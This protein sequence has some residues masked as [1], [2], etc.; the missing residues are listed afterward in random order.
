[1]NRI[2]TLLMIIG[3]LPLFL[4]IAAMVKLDSSGPVIFSQKRV[5]QQGRLF[6]MHKFRTMVVGMPDLPSDQ[7]NE[8]DSRITKVGRIL[9]RL[10]LDELPQLWN[11]MR[12][13]MNF[14]GPR[15]AL[16][17]QYE[18]IAMRM[19]QGIDSL[20]PGITG[21]AQVNGRDSISLERKVELDHY[22]LQHRSWNLDLKILWMTV[23]KSAVG[24]D[25]Y[26]KAKT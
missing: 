16:Y 8:T 4:I 2:I 26:S 18:L 23:F 15:P 21:W 22:Y 17:N 10:S 13:E 12:G 19:E 20:K 24:A 9:R 14:I 25:L 11:V 6:S 5:G 1:M 7:V 3:L